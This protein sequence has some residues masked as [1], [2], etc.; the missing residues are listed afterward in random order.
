MARPGRPT[1]L[2]D[3][4]VDRLVEQVARGASLND[5]A[6]ALG[7]APRT[8]RSWRQRAWSR[9]AADA[10]FVELERRLTAV[11]LRS[12]PATP[13]P[14]AEAWQSI[15]HRLAENDPGR[16]GSPDDLAVFD[17]PPELGLDVD[18]ESLFD[19]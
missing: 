1:L 13:E 10:P 16:W 2:R 7:I 5:A 12:L 9:A 11:R 8:L 19:R 18:V 4:V 15:A 17:D 6:L 3:D 14:V